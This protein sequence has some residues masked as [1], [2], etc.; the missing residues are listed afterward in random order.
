MEK[1][2]IVYFVVGKNTGVGVF[3]LGNFAAHADSFQLSRDCKLPADQGQSL[4]AP[5]VQTIQLI[6][7]DT[8]N[9][10]R[11]KDIAAAAATWNKIGQQIR[12]QD[13]FEIQYGQVPPSLALRYNFNCSETFGTP[14]ST[15]VVNVTS[16]KLWKE[17]GLD[18][19][20]DPDSVAPGVVHS[21]SNPLSFE[22]YQQVVEINTN[23]TNPLQ[24]KS[25]AIHELGHAL[26]LQHSCDSNPK[27]ASANYISCDKVSRGSAYQ[28]AVMYPVLQ[29]KVPGSVFPE[30]KVD[31]NSNDILRLE[32]LYGPR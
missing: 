5:I 30:Q 19:N 12:H 21:C 20:L 2:S 14:N 6:I 32:C 11:K 13:F 9:K 1:N 3:F 31:P 18:Q 7:D 27:T 22:L 29:K 23:M 28:Q 15:Y 4:R 25:V 16:E 24:F 26:G 8:F 10:D 17:M